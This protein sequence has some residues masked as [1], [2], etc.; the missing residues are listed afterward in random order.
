MNHKKTTDPF[1]I[2]PDKWEL[3]KQYKVVCYL[4][5]PNGTPMNTMVGVQY[6]DYKPNCHGYSTTL[7]YV[8][9]LRDYFLNTSH[10][11]IAER[12]YEYIVKKGKEAE[13][14]LFCK[15]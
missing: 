11:I 5:R 3:S 12:R 2:I 6:P 8:T 4:Q 9:I 1:E 13:K 14:I 7:D 15:K 10:M